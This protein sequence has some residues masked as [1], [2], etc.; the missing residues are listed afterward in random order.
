MGAHN[1]HLRLGPQK[2][3][4]TR[5]SAEQV[6]RGAGGTPVVSSLLWAELPHPWLRNPGRHWQ[7]ASKG[8]CCTARRG[9]RD[10][11]NVC[12]GA[13][14]M[15]LLGSQGTCL[16]TRGYPRKASPGGILLREGSQL[17]VPAPLSAHTSPL[18]S[19]PGAVLPGWS[20]FILCVMQVDQQ[21][22]VAFGED[23]RSL[24]EWSPC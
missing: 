7:E 5:S 10:R 3:V 17:E 11:E 19:P 9:Q 23:R 16:Q 21:V 22:I 14:R 18:S 6:G 13:T 15:S 4:R 12:D 24:S 8:S 1:T 2:A 20:S